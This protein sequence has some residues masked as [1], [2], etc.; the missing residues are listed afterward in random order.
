MSALAIDESPR[1]TALKVDKKFQPCVV[2]EGDECYPN[3][4]FEF[5]VT[6]MLAHIEAHAARFP[7]ALVE[8]A[9][10]LNYGQ[11]SQ[12]NQT[13]IAAADLSRPIVLAEIAAAIS[14]WQGRPDCL[15]ASA[16]T[17]LTCWA[18][19]QAMLRIRRDHQRSGPT[20]RFWSM[21]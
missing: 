16:R 3:G 15:P 13:A 8:V 9:A 4:I 19:R 7:I 10:I 6:R 17:T 21:D 20:A 1:W 2:E 11:D 18:P 12:M 14:S 5:N